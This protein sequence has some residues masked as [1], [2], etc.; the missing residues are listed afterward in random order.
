MTDNKMLTCEET[1]S[2]NSLMTR[3]EAARYLRIKPQTLAL[4]ACTGRYCLPYV[5]IGR[6]AMYRKSDLDAFLERRTITHTGQLAGR[7]ADG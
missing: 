4:W 6:R 1:V 7:D 5:R 3:V 2:E